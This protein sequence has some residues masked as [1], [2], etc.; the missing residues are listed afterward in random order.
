[1]T[2]EGL[3]RRAVR[4]ARRAQGATEPNPMVGALVVV[5]DEVVGEGH[6]RVLGGPHAEAEAIAA[7]GA[8][9]RGAT[10]YVTLEPCNHTGRTPPCTEAIRR[11]GI[12]R[13]VVGMRDPNPQ[14]QGGGVEALRA[15]GIEVSVDCA[16]S[17]CQELNAAWLLWL[18][19][20]RPLVTLKAAV[21]L[22]GWIAA[23]T[24]D[25]RWIS[26]EASRRLVA[27]MRRRSGAVL[28]G[29][30]TLRTDDP[31]LGVRAPGGRQPLRVGLNP[32]LDIPP[33]AR[34][35]T[36]RGGP[37]VIICAEDARAAPQVVLE[38]I[39]ADVVRVPRLAPRGRLDLRAVL[40]E[41]GRR[42]VLSVQV[43]GGGEIFRELLELGLADRVCVFVAPRILGG[44]DGVPFGGRTP[45]VERVALGWRLE[46]TTHRRVG[47]DIMILGRPVRPGEGS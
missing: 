30:G 8:A 16:R 35:L 46:D 38:G 34:V 21:T 26:G 40:A 43:E 3:M 37:V 13:V 5:G 28:V 24:G 11:A 36:S 4:L 15:A 42:G 18:S 20:G 17:E 22:D 31:R 41:L 1:M 44:V 32:D 6:H 33:D 7:A 29:P 12:A 25:S 27:R 10:L 19:E 2:P 14:V 23:S 9:C 39:G 45:G 47:D